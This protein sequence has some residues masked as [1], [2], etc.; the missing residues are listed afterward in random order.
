LQRQCC[1]FLAGRITDL[2]VL[3]DGDKAALDITAAIAFGV[4]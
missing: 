1:F 2:I 3:L 4:K